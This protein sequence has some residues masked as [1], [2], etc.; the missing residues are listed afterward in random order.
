[1]SRLHTHGGWRERPA[2]AAYAGHLLFGIVMALLGA[3]LPTLSAR[4]GIDLAQAGT[5]F[6]LMNASI[7]VVSLGLGP[8]LDRFGTKP[9]LVIGPVLACAGL[10]IVA[11]AR[12]YHA[13]AWGVALLGL[14]G[15]ALNGSSNTLV[16]D[17]HQTQQAR[18][19]ALNRLGVF[20]GLGAL[21]IPLAIGLLLER[22]ELA[23]ILLAGATLCLLVAARNA[24]IALPPP[25]LATHPV[26]SDVARLLRKPFVLLFAVLLFFEAGNEFVAGGYTASFLVRQLGFS[27]RAA[28]WA[29]AGYW[30]ALVLSRIAL[31]RVALRT[32]GERLLVLSALVSA[33]GMALLV[34]ARQPGV[35]VLAM[36]WIGAGIAGIF[37]TALGIVAARHPQLT[38]TVIGVLLTAAL[39]GGMLIPWL[40]GLVG[41]AHGLRPALAVVAAQFLA[42][43][44]IGA[45]AS[46]TR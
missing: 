13:L 14:G 40:T 25:K 3:I 31:G 34:V 26:L 28:S 2:E 11:L 36:L 35:A 27:V 15:G 41:E 37:P 42:I 29:L 39:A 8:L 22:A 9:P 32:S 4:L 23:S 19:A 24:L 1:M 7:L 46:R 6:L 38:G 30:A 12:Q 16:A 43:A 20:Y 45:I 5:L 44:G 10:T 17:L 18:S 21:V 33:A